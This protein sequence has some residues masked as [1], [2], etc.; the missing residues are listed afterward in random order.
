M[1]QG[2]EVRQFEDCLE[3]VAYTGKVKRKEFLKAGKYPIISQEQDFINGYWDSKSDVYEISKPIIVFGDH[4]KVLKFIDFD[5]V[6][7]ADGVKILQP[8]SSIDPKYFYYFLRSVNLGTLGYARHYRLLKEIKIYYPKSLKEQKQ[9]VAVLDEVFEAIHIAKALAEKN[10][11]NTEELSKSYSQIVFDNKGVNYEKKFLGELSEVI[12]KG[13]TPTSVGYKFT[14]EGINFIKVESLTDSGKIIPN[15]VAHISKECHQALKR[16]QLKINDILFS[17]AGALGRIG[18]V[19]SE[20]IPAN[21]NQ[22]LAIVRLKKDSGVL[23]EYLAK[24]FKS[25][26]IVDEIEKLRGGVAQQNLSLSQL[27]RLLIP[28][29]SINDQELIIKKIDALNNETKE[30]EAIYQIKLKNLEELKKTVLQKAFNEGLKT[31]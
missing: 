19:D 3:K 8:I 28:I 13:T 1:K 18:I 4:T 6:L 2:W 17:I 30:L 26:V 31:V 25:N 20:I 11:K 14:S 16:S 24:Y 22:A 5:F 23:V 7:G 27:N 9:I 10:L 12:T 15:K 21:T 29:P